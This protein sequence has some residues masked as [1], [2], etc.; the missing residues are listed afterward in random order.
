MILKATI[1]KESIDEVLECVN[2]KHLYDCEV[3]VNDGYDLSE[4]IYF[5]NLTTMHTSIVRDKLTL[6]LY[7]KFDD[8]MSVIWLRPLLAML[9]HEIKYEVIE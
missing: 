6:R 3:V 7:N 4:Q 9:T 8:Y 2:K 5:D 1:T